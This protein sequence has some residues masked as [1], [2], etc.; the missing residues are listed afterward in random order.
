M[1]KVFILETRKI[2]RKWRTYI[3]FITLAVIV[4]LIMLAMKIEG[5]H[6]IQ[7]ATRQL[8]NDFIFVGNLF[9]GWFI[10]HL[11][12]NSLFVHIPFLITLVAGDMLAGEATAGT[13]RILLTRPFSRM[14][15]LIIK[16]TTTIFYTTIFIL[17]LALLSLGLGLL[18]FG[19]GDLIIFGKE[20]LL[21][22]AEELWWRFTVAFVG[23]IFGMWTVASLAFLLSS[24][25]ENAIGPIIGTMAVL[26]VFLI[27]SQLPVKFFEPYKPYL[28]TTYFSVW[29]KA[30]EEPIN[31]KEYAEW[32]GYLAAYCLGLF[33]ITL[34]IFRRKDILS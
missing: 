3:G 2:F 19:S 8:Q 7:G 28:F 32:I 13:Y 17:F 23:A 33:L 11:I 6:F 34:Y 5:G 22:P 24:F 10:T 25:V 1:F 21:L 4:P 30:F 29:M 26:I 15:I 16:Y 31:W 27:I 20:I 14:K 12:M 9:N 18:I